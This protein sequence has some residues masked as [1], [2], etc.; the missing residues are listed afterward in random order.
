M[1]AS[2]LL[3]LALLAPAARADTLSLKDGRFVDRPE[4]ERTEERFV[5]KY[6]HGEIEVPADLVL[7]FFKEN[8]E[9]VYSPST[10]L[11]RKKFE[12][13]YARWKGRWIKLA[14]WEREMRK[15]KEKRR[16]YTEQLKER[17]FWRNHAVVK[18]KR[19]T[20]HHNLPDE[21][22]QEFQDLFEAYYAYFTKYWGFRPS[23]KFG[24]TSISIYHHRKYFEQV[25]G[26]P[27]GVLGWYMPHKR[28]LHFFY[29]RE[30]KRLTLDVMFH[31]GNH[32]L[33][34]MI[35]RN[36]WYPWWIGEGMAEYFGA[37]EWDPETKAMTLGKLQSGRLAVLQTQVK[38]EKWLKLKDML[39]AESMGAIEYAWAWSFCHFLLHTK[40]YEKK[41]KRYFMAIGRSS[42]IPRVS[43]FL[44]IRQLSP[45]VRVSSFKKY[46]R[47]SD[48]EAL[49]KEW[50]DYIKNQLALD[51]A[52]L[53][54]GRAGQTMERLGERGPARKFY[55]RA[56]DAGSEDA[57]VHYGYAKLKLE[58]RMPKTAHKYASRAVTYDPFHARAW[59]VQ[60]QALRA[61]EGDEQD[62]EGL[63]LIELA[64]EIDPDDEQ[65]W[66]AL[67]RARQE[68]LDK[69]KEAEEG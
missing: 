28:D 37:S 15:L 51:R 20:F 63:R 25:S 32:M 61:L 12:K 11:E 42:S 50:Y 27:E 65:I 16:L 43:R 31:E 48:L 64:Y 58:Q 1:R 3:A 13:G 55:K 4:I 40:E 29:D 33:T 57:F 46:M 53:D 26:A 36:M 56:I 60:G 35:D 66:F 67:E 24:K 18:T 5:V 21:L 14:Q 7:D 9:G 17:R 47:V 52:E 22:F 34:H 62:A 39:E 30:D 54:W 19:F 69:R 49:Q 59:M 23:A 41:F 6:E 38:D 8:E 44:T 2:L 45:E 10:E 68:E